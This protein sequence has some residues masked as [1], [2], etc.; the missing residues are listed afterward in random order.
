MFTVQLS[1]TRRAGKSWAAGWALAAICGMTALESQ[2]QPAPPNDNLTN[3]QV[4]LGTTG[5]L[6][7]T[8]IS[9]T[10][11]TGEPA[12]L[13]GV[14]AQSTIWYVWTAPIT[15]AFDFNTRNST[16]PGGLPLD[17]MLAV[18]TNTVGDPLSYA[19]L[20]EV[21]GNE[22]DPSGGVTSRVDFEAF[23]GTA[24]YIQ[25]GAT[26]NDPSDGYGQGYP[27]LNWNSSLLAGR[28]AFSQPTFFMSSFEN[29]LFDDE[30]DNS[31][32]PSLFGPGEGS[33][34]ARIEVRRLGG[35]VG[36]SEVD[37][38][39]SP[40]FYT[41]L[42][43][44]NYIITNI[45]I[46]NYS[47]LPLV[48]SNEISFTNI[49]LTNIASIN[50]FTNFEGDL[51]LQG[52][53][54]DGD[55]Q[56]DQTNS[57]TATTTNI[58]PVITT[59]ID[60]G[61]LGLPDFFTN[62]PCP[63][64]PHVFPPT[65]VS[66][67]GVITVTA[68]NIY[69]E[70]SNVEVAIPAAY[71]GI[72]YSPLAKKTYTFDDF[73]MSQDIFVQV[74]PG[75]FPGSDFFSYT[76]GPLDP[77]LAPDPNYAF[78]G[79]NSLVQV[80][81]SN[82][83][84]D[85]MENPDIVPPVAVE[86][87]AQINILNLWGNPNV[88][89][90]NTIGSTLMINF[91]RVADRCDK[92]TDGQEVYVYVWVQEFPDN[93]FSPMASHV[94]NYT[95]ESTDPTIFVVND[96]RF[97]TVADA[98]YAIPLESTNQQVADFGAPG[99]TDWNGL[100]GTLTFQ[101]G[102]PFAQPIFIPIFTNGAVE[103][104]M[105]I[106]VQLFLTPPNAQAD[107]TAMPPAFLG[108][109]VN[110]HLTVNF[111]DFEGDGIQPGGALDWAYNPDGQANSYPP[112]NLV[113]GANSIVNAV[114]IQA[115][116]EAVIGGDFD[117]YNTT[118]VNYIARL[119]TNGLMDNSLTGLGTGPNNFVNAVAIDA[120]G[121]MII[122]G[123]FTSINATNAFYIARLNYDGSIDSSFS[124][125]FGFN[126]DVYA[127]T[128]DHNGNILV[129]G[130][131]TSFNKTNCN[132][133]TRLLPSGEMDL[134]F[135]P[136]SGIG[137]TNG[138]DQDVNAIAVDSVGNIV[139]GGHFT[140]VNGTNWNHIARLLPNGSLDKTFNLGFGADGD[141]MA[142]AMQPDNSIILGGAFQHFNLLSR[143][144]IARLAPSGALDPSFNPGSGFD[145][146]VYSLVRQPN[147]YILAGG[148]FTMYNGV[149]RVGLARLIG[150]QLGQGG[151][152]DTSFMDT[153]YN[154]FAGL[155]NHYYN[156][157]AF[158][159]N[160]FASASN[161]RHQVL[162][163]GLQ[164]DGNVIIGG[165]FSRL[166]G[167]GTRVDVHIRQNVARIIGP[168]TPGPELGGIGNNPGNL[169]LTQNPYTVDD[170]GGQLY[171]TLN[172]QNGSL[173]LATVSLGTN[174]LPP[175]SSSATAKD[176]GLLQPAALYDIVWDLAAVAGDVYGWRM[177]DGEY[178]TNDTI[179]TVPDGGESA[180]FLSI[181]NDPS[182]APILDADLNLLNLN[183]NDLLALGGVPIP[184]EPA[185]G[186]SS[187]QL[188]IIND[189]F[190]DGTIGFSATNYNVLESAG[191]VTLTLYRT[192]GLTGSPSV[193]INTANGT[194]IDGTDFQWTSQ[195]VTF[196]SG[197]ASKT[198]TIPIDDHNT[199]Q[200]NKFFSVFLSSPTQGAVLDTNIPP[201]VPS[202]T[203]VTIIDDHFQPGYL[204]FSAP[205]YS[206]LKA[207]VA[208]ISVVRSGAALGQLS[209]EVGT[210]NGTAINNLNYIGVTNTLSWT[211]LDISPKT[212]TIQTLQD[213]TVEGN[214]TVNLFLF[215]AIVNGNSG[216]TSNAQVL[217]SPSNAVLTIV[218]TDSYGSLNFLSPN[219]NV[220]Q[221]GG[222]AL[223]TVSRTGG[224]VGTVSVDYQ[225][226]TPTNV[227]LPFQA[228]VP[229]SN[230]SAA[231]GSLTFG[232]GVSSQSFTI[233]II[234]TPGESNLADRIVGL[235]LFS[236]NPSNIASQFP[237]T[238]ILII[239]DP[240]LHLNSAGSV[241]T[242]TQNGVGFNNFV[243]SLSLQPDGSILAG[244]EFSYFNGYP[245]NFVARLLSSGAFDTG[246]QNDLIGP[247]ASVFQVLS[248]T[249]S[250][251]L[252]NG[253][254]MIVGDFTQV[255]QV[256][257]PGIARLN[258]DG[259]LDT[260]FNPGAG[261]DGIVY[262]IAQMFLPSAASNQSNLPYYVIG[263]TFANFN[264][265][266][267]SAVARVTP[268]GLFVPNFNIG[269]C[270]ARR[271]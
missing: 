137:I 209:V 100:Y 41:N 228:A 174:T 249:A 2:A 133:I 171:V 184:L 245:F 10:V 81:L 70:S 188:E 113:P 246:F 42:Y 224:T 90:S 121:R 182:A 79:L 187:A 258:L 62:F 1:R 47:N 96:N 107:A 163:M 261:A 145:D 61:Q 104:D 270:V 80:T 58:G 207:G 52:L 98:D 89:F 223:I 118:P 138:T 247:N 106:L 267:A 88:A 149:R 132:H 14:P 227:L 208:T 158:N 110:S 232:P 26:T 19:T 125:G 142:L 192:N 151:W 160:D 237:K 7:A 49:F 115:N 75:F 210:S 196:E 186:Q 55:I 6:Q 159:T 123:N 235:R 254:I 44:T 37:V 205:A 48:A 234:D 239:L 16:T 54:V 203:V 214:N 35:A 13:P 152:L 76:P 268:A 173:G 95:L 129:G 262:S 86:P 257:R 112:H 226:Y 161:Q 217:A 211:N 148:Q 68:M 5:S 191:T 242:T 144:S 256:N 21:V 38:T 197:Q 222:S 189:N 109:V 8:N 244:G 46:T 167:G 126:G 120:N 53:P 251:G 71:E 119:Q 85:P 4:I 248:Q 139:L 157:N 59:I 127:L 135:L 190:A 65:M 23:Q 39:L 212:F 198:F 147:G 265:N 143:N 177:G 164:T 269:Q 83:V 29:W 57:G 238:A 36:R 15:G 180:L 179:L 169:G 69:C 175:S 141:V 263:G 11:E 170:T 45:F 185:F 102:L 9:A 201:L 25:V 34:N 18:Y 199:Q 253:D 206:V 153:G 231:S 24:Y 266:P 12:P 240:Q 215:N 130:D 255:N 202:N 260:S 241:D 213:N 17:T 27:H 259:Q 193:T 66:N 146:I 20:G 154:Q 92:L 22:A 117:A 28:F 243:D 204:S 131:F 74:Y 91:E 97:A 60:I 166:G 183:A 128:I 103:F 116:G 56:Q 93:S 200:S 229:G 230:Y 43:Q 40:V 77:G 73:Q 252:T 172:R 32:G 155:I 101:P 51:G 181:N 108:N 87:T 165:N 168:S 78:P 63:P 176:F 195:L 3:A 50:W 140:R 105:D 94:V 82:L 264:G 219:F 111:D 150:G 194:A 136:S 225:T 178:G 156:T 114:A 33:P 99:N 220:F 162:A 216:S 31:I 218:D 250:T 271:R 134:S 122:G 67:N 84:L 30:P 236:G 233:P 124:T 64:L 72:M 221:N